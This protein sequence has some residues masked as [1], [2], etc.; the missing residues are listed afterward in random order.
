MSRYYVE[1]PSGTVLET[2]DWTRWPEARRLSVAK[3]KAIHRA[4]AFDELHKIL[5][6]GDEVYTIVTHVARSGMSRSIRLF[7]AR[8]G[9]IRD[10][11]FRVARLLDTPT[12]ERNGGLRVGGC[13]MDMCFATVY[14]LGRAMF[15]NGFGCAGKKCR[16]NEHVNGDRDYTPHGCYDDGVAVHR[17]PTPGEAADGCKKHWHRDG[18]YALV[19]RDL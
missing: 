9:G 18:G 19:Q 14:N 15:E 12:D 2:D 3:G 13:G 11:T 4:E 10:I 6:P 8:D 16:S 17:D 1:L 7:V 5:K